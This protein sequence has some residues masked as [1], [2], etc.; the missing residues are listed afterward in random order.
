MFD[1]TSLTRLLA[2][3]DRTYRLF[4][5]ANALLK[6]GAQPYAAV[7][8]ALSFADAAT[9]WLRK[10]RENL[11]EDVRPEAGDLDEFSHLFVSYLST[12]FEV[13]DNATVPACRWCFCC[14]VLRLTRRHLRVRNPDRKA[15]QIAQ[16]MKLIYL[17]RLSEDLELPLIDSDLNQFITQ[18]EDL[19][20]DLSL[21]TYAQELERRSHFASQGEGV[22]ALW[23][24][25]ARKPEGRRKPKFQL[26]VD[27][28]LEAEGRLADRLKASTAE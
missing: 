7:S 15:R 11:P 18:N 12:S 14:G 21:V 3:H 10:N 17:R 16:E 1:R 6:D 2:L 5:W 8:E 22:L 25:F 24:E 4:L 27:Q 19:G 28:I 23:R 26:K 20:K 9:A 13:V